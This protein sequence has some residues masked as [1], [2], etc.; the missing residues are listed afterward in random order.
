MLTKSREKV[1]KSLK[2]KK[3]RRETGLFIVEGEKSV[4][5]ALGSDFEVHSIYLTEQFLY[6]HEQM[7]DSYQAETIVVSQSELERISTFKTNRNALM[8]LKIKE[9]RVLRPEK[10]E[11]VIML[12]NV[13]DPGNL[14]T[15]IRISDWYGVTKLVLS[16]TSADP[17]NPKVIASSMGSFTRVHMYLTDLIQY[18]NEE[19]APIYAT[20]LDGDSVHST[21]I[22]RP[23]YLLF[24][25]ESHGIDP[26]LEKLATRKISIPKAGH[27]ESLNVAMATGIVLD[28]AM[29]LHGGP[30]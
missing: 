11:L 4:L 30:S 20:T 9:N 10:A 22:E 26:R 12:D 3:N 18:A 17:Y 5:E 21:P 13:R 16:E 29:R 15:I 19:S 24:G 23:G 14:G 25:N 8:V 2:L 28:N 6:Q 1:I 27:A 7:V